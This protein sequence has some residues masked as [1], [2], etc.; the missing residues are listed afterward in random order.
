[1]TKSPA[2]SDLKPLVVAA[3]YEIAD[4]IVSFDLRARDGA[5]LAQFTAGAHVSVQAPNGSVRKY[6]LSNDPAEV[7]RYVIAVKREAAGRGGSLSMVDEVKEDDEVRVGPPRND[8]PLEP[9]AREFLFIAGG[10]GIT[11]ILSMMRH[12]QTTDT[13]KFQLIYLTRSPA[14]TAFRAELAAPEF[15]GRVQLHHD[16]GD[17]RQALDLWPYLEHP[18]GRHI[19]CCGPAPLMAE[20]RDMTGHWSKT[21][22]HFESFAEGTAAAGAVNLPFKLRLARAAAV[23]DVG[24][25]ETILEALRRN[26]FDAPSSCES[27]SCGTCRTKLLAGEAEHRDF[28]LDA[29]ERRREIMLCVSRAKTAELTVD[30]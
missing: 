19:Y 10:I 3:R 17:A 5:A 23:L 25:G 22:V 1:M 12:L 28:V 24:A 7:D 6:S 30:L 11:P 16:G 8:F 2:A 20:V 27:G 15:R 14:V 26:G 29:A 18:K 13:G 21:N 4:G 9:K